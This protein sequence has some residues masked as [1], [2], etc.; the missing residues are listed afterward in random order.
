M[1]IFLYGP[2]DYRRTKKKREIIEEFR[3]KR[4]N[5]GLASFDLETDGEFDQ[6]QEFLK[7]QSLFGAAKLAV[8]DN[9]FESDTKKTIALLKLAYEDKGMQILLSEKSKPVKAFAFLLEKPAISQKFEQL[10]AAELMGFIAAEAKRN[11]IT[12]APPAAQFLGMVF[13]G[14]SWGLATEIEKLASLKSSINRND[15]DAFDLDAAPNYWALLNGMKSFDLKNRLSA[16]ETLFSINDPAPK[17]FNILAAQWAEKIPHMA[18]YDLAVK[19]GK[20]DYEE[21]LLDLAIN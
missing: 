2:D 8:V 19:S 11:G 7:N 14:N 12:I 1:I 20:I 18:E 10:E 9:V 4:S 17:I 16:L 5:L 15:L 3:K 21:A 6:L 13:Q